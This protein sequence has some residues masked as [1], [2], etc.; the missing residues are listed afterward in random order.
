MT[1]CAVISTTTGELV[2]RIVAEPTDLPPDGCYLI[3][4]PEGYYW[5]GTA[6]VPIE[7]NNGN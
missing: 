5:N 2:N 6:V 3:E 7:I 4:L 1:I